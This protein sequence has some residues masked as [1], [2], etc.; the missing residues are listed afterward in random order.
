MIRLR[1]MTGESFPR[2]FETESTLDEFM[3]TPSEALVDAM[4][5]Y[6]G[7]MAVLGIGGK[8]G[9]T[10]GRQARRAAARAGAKLR[11]VGVSRFG[12][13]ERRRRIEECGVETI[14]CDLLDRDAVDALPDAEYVVFMAGRKFGTGGSESLTWAMNT[15]VPYHVAY[16]F[17]NAKIVAFS[18]G[19]VYPFVAVESGGCR[20]TDPVGPVGEYAESCLGRER[21]F[22]Y[23]SEN[24]G[25]E[26]CLVRLNYAIDLRYGVLY[27]IARAV[28]EGRPVDISVPSFNAIWQGDATD[29][30]LRAFDLVAAPAVPLNITGPETIST[31]AAADA[32]GD[33]FG[34]KVEYSGEPAGRALLSNATKALS[35]FGYPKVS[36]GR[37]IEWTA[38]WVRRGGRTLGKPTHFEST[39]G[40]F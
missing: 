3:S 18:T 21:V 6:R 8:M 30:I 25:A 39:D 40:D 35:L 22:E 26:V 9:H 10:L 16:R 38:D 13:S 29:Q 32:F 12:D 15:L 37:M 20:E 23:A 31:R 17:R 1:A 33:L 36:L 19:C 14:A 11:I 2:R 5:R 34:K 7:T 27:D 28:H 24:Y 4:S